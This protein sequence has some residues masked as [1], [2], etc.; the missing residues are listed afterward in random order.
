[1]PG[2]FRRFGREFP[3]LRTPARFPNRPFRQPPLTQ[4]LRFRPAWRERAAEEAAISRL[5][6]GEPA[7][8]VMLS[9]HV[10]R[11][12]A[13]QGGTLSRPQLRSGF[14]WSSSKLHRA[15]ERGLL[16]DMAPG[17]YLLASHTESFVA[18]CWAA[19][20]FGAGIG[21]ISGQSAA[22]WYGL[23][24]MNATHIEYTVP[25]SFRRVAPDWMNLRVTGWY[26][27]AEDRHIRGGVWMAT[28]N[29]MA[30]SLGGTFNQFRF[31]RAADDAWNLGLIEPNELR[32]YLERHRCKGKTGVLRIETWLDRADAQR[33]P[34]HSYLERDL[35]HAVESLGL[36]ALQRQWP[37][38]LSDGQTI[39]LDAAWPHLR[40]ALEPGAS[41][42]HQPGADHARDQGCLELGWMVMRIDDHMLSDPMECARSVAT[43]YRARLRSVKFSP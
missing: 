29:R 5:A 42:W 39:R 1:M 35:I 8:E 34:S 11:R 37:L 28:P 3:L 24:K 6:P 15:R 2:A 27:Q 38:V 31:D 40:F 13:D 23:R 43:A 9:T 19:H 10:L 25:P 21:F 16:I 36:P 20:H 26:R 4:L 12:A 30:F 7:V 14:G 33:A 32:T 17:V 22:R 18:R 41:W